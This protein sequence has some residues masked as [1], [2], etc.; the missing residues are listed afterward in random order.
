MLAEVLECYRTL[1]DFIYVG[2]PSLQDGGSISAKILTESYPFCSHHRR[3]PVRTSCASN[4]CPRIC[5][6]LE[7]RMYPK[8]LFPLVEYR[9]LL[10]FMSLDSAKPLGTYGARSPPAHQPLFTL[11]WNGTPD[12]CP[13]IAKMIN[14]LLRGLNFGVNTVFTL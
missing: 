2:R 13:D 12:L 9:T 5:S 14:L 8:A 4:E 1:L 7:T 11:G 3:I 10:D 6:R